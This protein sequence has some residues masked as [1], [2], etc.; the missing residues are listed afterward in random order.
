M[1]VCVCVRERER[2]SECACAR[3]GVICVSVKRSGLPTC[4][5]VGRRI[6]PLC[7]YDYDCVVVFSSE[8]AVFLDR[9]AYSD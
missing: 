1:C 6:N 9:I 8:K 5:D 3:L 7:Y 2:E 4:V